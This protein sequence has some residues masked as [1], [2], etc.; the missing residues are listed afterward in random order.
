M[1]SVSSCWIPKLTPHL[2]TGEQN[3]KQHRAHIMDKMGIESL[4]DLV[5][6]AE[7]LGIGK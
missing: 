6:A 5:R 2:G 1:F 4:T 3:I 7:R